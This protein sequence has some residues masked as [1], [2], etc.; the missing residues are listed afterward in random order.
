MQYI[1][2]YI[3]NLEYCTLY[4][5]IL[6]SYHGSATGQSLGAKCIDFLPLILLEYH[7]N[8]GAKAHSP[9][10]EDPMYHIIFVSIR[11]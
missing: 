9:T 2:V 4:R 6:I 11:I 1:Y 10:V 3:K 5:Y 7:K 8:L